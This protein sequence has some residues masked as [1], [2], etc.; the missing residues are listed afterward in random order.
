MCGPSASGAAALG[1]SLPIPQYLQGRW[2]TLPKCRG[3]QGEKCLELPSQLPHLEIPSSIY[4]PDTTCTPCISQVISGGGD[5]SETAQQ[6]GE[7]QGGDTTGLLSP[8]GAPLT[9]APPS[10]QCVVAVWLR[11]VI[12][13][14]FPNEPGLWLVGQVLLSRGELCVSGFYGQRQT[15]TLR[16]RAALRASVKTAPAMMTH[17]SVMPR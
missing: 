10:E 17:V 8:H 5:G 14:T 12:L 7:L 16:R 9:P 2:L 1:L 4:S 6:H 15:K 11:G 3:N 13:F